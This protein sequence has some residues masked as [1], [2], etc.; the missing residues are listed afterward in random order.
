[1]QRVA[2]AAAAAQCVVV[3]VDALTQSAALII[4]NT[5]S[6]LRLIYCRTVTAAA[7]WSIV[8]C[9]KLNYNRTTL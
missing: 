8:H 1:M 7:L 2:E 4:H 6:V 9:D 3:L 5:M